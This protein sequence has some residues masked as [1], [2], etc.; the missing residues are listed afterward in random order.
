MCDFGEFLRRLGIILVP[1]GMQ[2]L[3]ELAIGA[4][5][6]RFGGGARYAKCLIRIAK[7]LLHLTNTPWPIRIRHLA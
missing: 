4:L 1:V 5:D 7:S 6:L 2:L 3:G